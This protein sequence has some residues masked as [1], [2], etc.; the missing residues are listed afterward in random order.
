MFT[1]LPEKANL[2]PLF[3]EIDVED[4]MQLG[5]TA[6]GGRTV[7]VAET[8]NWPFSPLPQKDCTH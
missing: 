2:H 1:T 3:T 7:F 8:T 5:F 4:K 6:E